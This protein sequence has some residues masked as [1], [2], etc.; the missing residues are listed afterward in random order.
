MS[1]NLRIKE[2]RLDKKLSQKKFGEMLNR[3]Q[4]QIANIETGVRNVSIRLINDLKNEFNVNPEWMETGEGNKFISP[5]D[6]LDIKDP[7]IKKLAELFTQLSDEQKNS[8]LT[9]LRKEVENIK[10]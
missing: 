2:I 6:E 9:E 3:T 4:S 5:L 8:I 1:K 10:K 7:E